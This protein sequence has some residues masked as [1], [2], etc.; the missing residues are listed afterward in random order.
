MSS[1]TPPEPGTTFVR[2][3]AIP[4]SVWGLVENG[5]IYIRQGVTKHYPQGHRWI[6]LDLRQLG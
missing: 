3:C 4:D 1:V 5:D 6:K 2:L